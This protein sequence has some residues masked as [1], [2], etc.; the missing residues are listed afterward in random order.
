MIDQNKTVV[1]DT[2]FNFVDSSSDIIDD[3]YLENLYYY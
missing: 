2:R 1:I 3:I